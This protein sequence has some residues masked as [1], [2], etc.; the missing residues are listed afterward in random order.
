MKTGGPAVQFY[1]EH[2][3]TNPLDVGMFCQA[4]TE[5]ALKGGGGRGDGALRRSSDNLFGR[6]ALANVPAPDNTYYCY[7][8]HSGSSLA[9]SPC[10]TRF[11][12]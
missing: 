5:E 9:P 10:C 11:K 2:Y 8:Y 7:V 6:Q 3:E 4:I 1:V 12:I